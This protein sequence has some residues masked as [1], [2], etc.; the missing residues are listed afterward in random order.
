MK[1][2]LERLIEGT[3]D[4]GYEKGIMKA[5]NADKQFLKVMEELIELKEEMV[6]YDRY[7]NSGDF[8]KLDHDLLEEIIERQEMEFGDVLVTLVVLAGQLGFH[9]DECLEK[10]YNKISKRK[11]KVINGIF[12]K[13]EDLKD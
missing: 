5:E 9:W 7:T 12:V 6:A 1:S 2:K 4:W 8:G 11:G 3:K 10:A 13:E